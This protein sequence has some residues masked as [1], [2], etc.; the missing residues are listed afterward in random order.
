[1][2]YKRVGKWLAISLAMIIAVTSGTTAVQAET[3]SSANYQ[4]TES[5]FNSSGSEQTCSSQ[6]CARVAIGDSTAG[7]ASSANNKVTFGSITSEEPVLEMIV[8]PGVS[9]LGT[10]TTEH[11]GT[12][13]ASVKV[14]TYNSDGYVLRIM[15]DPP[16]YS[17]HTLAAPV[18]P[19]A[20][21]VGTEQFGINVVAN[22]S[23][24]V[25]ANPVQVPSGD[26]S[27]GEVVAGYNIANQF[28]Y[29][30]G[31]TVARSTTA[32]GETDYTI[33]MIVN[34]AQNTPAGLYRGEYSIVAIPI[35]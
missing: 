29:V 12:K 24:A 22:T 34:I 23:P 26:F 11:T 8:A 35:F 7:D 15:G 3:S 17:S 32:S 20:S 13:T 2:Q 5:E 10:L 30:S 25:G 6:F 14:R 21:S 33:S 19:T 16:N 4:M 9:N 1:M 31:E 28:K 27:F 18:M